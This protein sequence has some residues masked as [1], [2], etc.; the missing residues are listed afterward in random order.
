MQD[1]KSKWNY[2]KPEINQFILDIITI[3]LA[4]YAFFYYRFESG[5]LISSV[6]N[7]QEG[8]GVVNLVLLI[9]WIIVFACCGL[10]KNMYV[11][12][13]FEELWRLIKASVGGSVVIYFLIFVDSNS[14]PRMSLLLYCFMLIC[15]T[16]AGR[17]ISRRI[18]TVLRKHRKIVNNTIVIAT[19]KRANEIL[20]QLEGATAWGMKPLGYVEIEKSGKNY[21]FP[22][23]GDVSEID[24]IIAE[25]KP[26]EVVIADET[27]NHE[28]M[29]GVVANCTKNKIIV[30][31]P[32]SLYDIFTGQVRTFP[33]FGIPFIEIDTCLLKPWEKIVKRLIDIVFSAIVLI[34]GLPFW[35]LIALIVHLESPGGVF[36]TQPRVGKN[37]EIFKIYKF[38]SMVNNAQKIGG[39]WTAVNDSRVTKFG[40]FIRKAH[41]D[42]IPQF[43]NVL[44][45][46]MSIVGPRPE[47][48]TIVEKYMNVY[49]IYGRRLLVRPGITGWWQ[50]NYGP[51]Q[52]NLEEIKSRLKDD[53][54]YIENMSIK[55][56]IEIIIRT[57]FVVLK[58]HGQA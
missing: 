22:R 44:I 45:G 48:P 31:I 21:K 15:A 43:W 24:K 54:Y 57:V 25:I 5:L 26:D 34:V 55:L 9:Y 3:S 10:Y 1:N 13:P 35:V 7:P 27:R 18:Q 39:I 20:Q 32:P 12:S 17:Y 2:L 52:E 37:S 28:L 16:F 33:M 58:G 50:I 46:D 23:L 49:P 51:H 41:L 53:F 6:N 29:F 14:M 30:K 56:D 19:A 40:R 11:V 36:Y 42:E 8:I 38:R 4:F 47:Q